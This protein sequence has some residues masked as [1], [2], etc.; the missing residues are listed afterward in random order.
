M[1]LWRRAADATAPARCL[2][3][4]RISTLRT[5]WRQRTGWA[6]CSQRCTIGPTCAQETIQR[7]LSAGPS[8]ESSR[9]QLIWQV[10]IQ[11][12]GRSGMAPR[13]KQRKTSTRTR[14]EQATETVSTALSLSTSQRWKWLMGAWRERSKFSTSLTNECPLHFN[15]RA[16]SEWASYQQQGRVE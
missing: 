4:P 1:W 7:S 8:S 14:W 3:L 12:I 9:C 2:T 15:R 10:A 11:A 6:L 16:L 13:G 5:T